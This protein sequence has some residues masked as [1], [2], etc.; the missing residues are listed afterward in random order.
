MGYL[1]L[2][3]TMFKIKKKTQQNVYF[4]ERPVG[5]RNGIKFHSN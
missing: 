3:F 4:V 1:Q 2:D 5:K